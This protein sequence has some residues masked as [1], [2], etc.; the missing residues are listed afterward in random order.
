MLTF[1]TVGASRDTA[2]RRRDD[3]HPTRPT[4]GSH[5]APWLAL[6]AVTSGPGLNH[7]GHGAPGYAATG[8]A[9]GSDDAS[10]CCCLDSSRGGQ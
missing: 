3:T 1:C 10:A 9:S 5:L 6:G 8:S 4:R 2:F 7:R